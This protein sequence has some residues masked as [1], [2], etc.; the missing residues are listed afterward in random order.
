MRQLITKPFPYYV[1]IH[2]LEELVTKDSRVC[3]VNILGNESRK[4]TPISHEYSGGNVVAG[5]QYGREGVLETKIGDIPVYRSVRDVMN[6]GIWFDIGVIYLPPPAVAQAVWEFVRFNPDLKRIVIV[7]EKV[8]VRDSRNVRWTCQNAGVDV[9]GANCLGIA[10]V[11]DHVRVGGALG[12]DNPEE[13]LQKGSI[14]IHSNSGNFTTTIAQYL[15]LAGFGISTAVSSGK[16]VYI[17]FAL[18]EFLYA[19]QNDPRTKAVALYV[20]P[21]GYYEKQALDWIK[22]RRFGFNKPIVVCVTGRWKKNITRA[23]GHAGAL[24]GSG[25]DAESKERWFDEYF[26]VPPFDPK[27]PLV[28]KRGVRV[29]SIQHFPDAMR[30]VFEKIDEQ[31]DFPPTG[32]LSLKLWISDNIVKLPKELHL[33]VVQ[34]MS[35]YDEQIKEINKQVGASYIRQNM[36]NKSGAS[37]MDPATQVA[38]LHGKSVLELSTTSFEENLFFALAKVMP[39]R[40]DLRRM[41]LL[42]NMFLKTEKPLLELLEWADAAGCSPNALL[43][44]RTALVGKQPFLEQ[45]RSDS[46]LIIDLLREYPSFETDEQERLALDGKISELLLTDEQVPAHDYD[47]LLYKEIHHT[48]NS[49][50]PVLLCDHVIQIAQER[51]KGIR[52]KTE[53]LLAALIVSMF[54][55][56]MLEKRISR[57]TAEDAVFYIYLA[58]QTAA[59]SVVDRKENKYWQKLV[60]GTTPYLGS[61]FSSN[62]F[63]ILFNRKPSDEELTEFRYLLGLTATNGPGTLSAKGAKESVSARNDIPTAF[64]GFLT[65]TGYAHGGNGYEAVEYLL[66]QFENVP[67]QDPGKKDEAINL[68]ELA[69]RAAKAYAAYKQTMRDKGDLD[70]RRIPCINHPVF[71]G[72]AVNI[73]PREDFIRKEL[74]GK[75]IYNAFHE[76]YHHLVVELHDEGVTPNVFCVNV[77]AVLAVIALKLMWKDLQE[78][79]MTRA[80]AQKVVFL[81]FLLGRTVGTIAEIIDH[82]DRGMDMDCRTPQE[83]VQFVL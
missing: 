52:N 49:R 82:R 75:G 61:S 41:N 57:Q 35:P 70:I 17:H 7:T 73:D 1:G 66:E 83:E 4:V 79:R 25:D 22:E 14:A 26:E 76:F 38:E 31:P 28:S 9:I 19:A 45:I 43:A 62:L 15:K 44:A 42:L 34:A 16:D 71:K 6:K 40:R 23:C 69:N 78:G 53:F 65:N 67:L 64:A 24:A 10:N 54:W 59:F 8:S 39:G 37:C 80:Q 72:N 74:E 55:N 30:A 56:E 27:N 58:A 51:G 12:G 32:D 63:Q 50:P 11:W 13:A 20:E 21:G 36:R 29:T 33:P 2:S 5:V 60:S 68:R 81:L 77:D 48:V 47:D 46:R 18:A 3:V